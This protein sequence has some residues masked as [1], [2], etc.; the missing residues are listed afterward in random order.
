MGSAVHLSNLP[1]SVHRGVRGS[2]VHYSVYSAHRG[3]RGAFVQ[4]FPV[5]LIELVER[6]PAQGEVL[7]VWCGQVPFLSRLDDSSDDVDRADGPTLVVPHVMSWS[8]QDFHNVGKASQY[9]TTCK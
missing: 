3:V 7:V 8:L 4:T 9:S 1:D 5:P 6:C 2:L